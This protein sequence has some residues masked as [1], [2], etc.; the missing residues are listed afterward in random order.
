M[1]LGF[2]VVLALLQVGVTFAVPLNRAD[3]TNAL[4]QLSM[5]ELQNVL[6][7]V[8]VNHLEFASR[9][10]HPNSGHR[11]CKNLPQG[12]A[13]GN[14]LIQNST[15]VLNSE[16]CD[17]NLRF[18]NGTP[19]WMRVAHLHMED[20]NQRCPSGLQAQQHHHRCVRNTQTSGCTSVVYPTN[21][22]AYSRVCGKIRAIQ[23]SHPAG[24]RPYMQRRHTVTLEGSYVDGVSLTHGPVGS[25]KHI[26]TF[27]TS[28]SDNAMQCS[29]GGPD[30]EKVPPFIGSDFFCETG[31]RAESEYEDIA[32]EADPLWD[33]E[34]C[35]SQADCCPFNRPPW[36]CKELPEP[37]T[38]DIEMRVCLNE[39]PLYG[40]ILIEAV[41][42]YVQ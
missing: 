32:F 7:E 26:W 25:R 34:G 24:F 28:Y 36:F 3:L 1:L 37:T 39:H 40:D 21:G 13:S 22:I 4:E 19:G 29:C 31:S 14:Y 38:D 2:A 23:Y 33:G 9:Q 6:H 30:E 27:A 10:N 5:N 18:M 8:H 20:S 16:Y 12:S 17:T 11:S 15:G 35:D 41:D 42:I